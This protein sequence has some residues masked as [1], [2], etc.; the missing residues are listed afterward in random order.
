MYNGIGLNTPRGSG[1]SG[2]VVRNMSALKPGQADRGR[3]SQQYSRDH[4]TNAKPVDKGIIEHERRR[5][6]E[7]KCLELQD[8]LETQGTLDDTEIEERVDK[9][10]SQLLESIDQLDFTGARPIK[11]FE[12]QKLAE[13]KSKENA[14]LA[15]ALRVEEEYVEGAAFDRELQ[16]LKR[17]RKLLEKERDLD[18]QR[19]RE[20]ERE[21]H[22]RYRRS[23]RSR[24]PSRDSNSDSDHRRRRRRSP[25]RRSND[26]RR[27]DR[28]ASSESGSISSSSES[29]S[30]SSVASR[31]RHQ[32]S[33]RRHNQNSRHRQKPRRSPSPSNSESGSIHSPALK[34]SSRAVED[35]E[36]GEIEDLEPPHMSEESVAAPTT[37][38]TTKQTLN[39][40]PI[41][42]DDESSDG[43]I[44]E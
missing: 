40:E 17:Q 36:P 26:R 1:T 43:C 39:A 18:R 4:I 5:Q 21:S 24:S 29:D 32:S 12:T 20:R 11:S 23:N 2:H 28:S 44:G 33:S 34:A 38:E 35:G 41:Y 15:S 22:R 7:V 9:L 42:S 31:H 13:A 3:Q 27:R 30:G 37:A 25:R 10:R 6:V 8:E 14:R 16:E 19:E